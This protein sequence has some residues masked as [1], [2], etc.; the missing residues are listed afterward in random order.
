MSEEMVA[1]GSGAMFDAIAPR[2]DL[3]NRLMSF[4][5][6]RRWRT[7]TVKALALGAGARVLD[8]AT[9]TGDLAIAIAR[10]HT[11]AYVIGVDPSPGMLAIGRTKAARFGERVEMIEGDAQALALPD[12][13]FDGACI[14]FGI[15][16]VPDRACGLA[17][18]RRVVRP[19]G[20]VCVL[21]LGEP[22][23]G[24]LGPLARFHVHHVVPRMGALISGKR[25][26]RYLQRSI[27]AFPPPEQFGEMMTA[28]GLDLVEIVPLTF[29]VCHL[30]VAEVPS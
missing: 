10:R 19:G 30:Y 20:R 4:G 29:G 7:R 17:E 13:S 3:L 8:V 24:V 9:G 23:G 27:A 14:A 11:D 6:D 15:R 26:Y 12:A 1:P 22:R 18:M 2:Y 25:E 28:A 5:V 21:E 16:N